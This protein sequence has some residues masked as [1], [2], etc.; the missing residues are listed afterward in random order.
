MKTLAKTINLTLKVWRQPGP[1]AAGKMERYEAPGVSPDMSFLEM[2]DVLNHDLIN[3]GEDPVAVDRLDVDDIAGEAGV[4]ANRFNRFMRQLPRRSTGAV[5]HRDERW[6]QRQ[7]QALPDRVLRGV[8]PPAVPWRVLHQPQLQR[9]G[10]RLPGR[11]AD[12][13]QR[14]PARGPV[15]TAGHCDRHQGRHES[16]GKRCRRRR[17]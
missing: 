8:A 4:F 11:G 7:D 16:S 17:R 5:G 10:R 15:A 12:Y 14:G 13:Q 6:P 1:D 3:R 2:L 9:P